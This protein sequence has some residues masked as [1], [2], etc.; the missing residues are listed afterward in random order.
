MG[1]GCA[2]VKIYADRSRHLVCE[3]YSVENLH[4]AAE[5]L[6]IKRCWFHGS[7]RH[8]HYDIPKRMVESVLSDAR[9]TVVTCRDVLNICRG[10]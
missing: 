9:I 2:E 7:A 5:M 10:K 6:G 8:K 3:P 4:R 1:P